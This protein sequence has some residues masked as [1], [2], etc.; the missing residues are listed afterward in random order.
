[1]ANQILISLKDEINHL[2]E[3]RNELVEEIAEKEDLEKALGTKD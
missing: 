2:I 1:L 3:K